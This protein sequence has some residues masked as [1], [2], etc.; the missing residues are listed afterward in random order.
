MFVTPITEPIYRD[1]FPLRWIFY[2]LLAC[3]HDNHAYKVGS[4]LP[5]KCLFI[6]LS[7]APRLY[8]AGN[9]EAKRGFN[10]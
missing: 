2:L 3:A 8:L 9:M 6:P 7:K 4:R 10:I 5:R 1:K